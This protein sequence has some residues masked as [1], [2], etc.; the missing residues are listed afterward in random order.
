MEI[1]IKPQD[2][3]TLTNRH[4]EDENERQWMYELHYIDTY[5]TN[6]YVELPILVYDYWLNY[7]FFPQEIIPIV[8]ASGNTQSTYDMILQILYGDQ[9]GNTSGTTFVDQ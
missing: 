9:S 5:P 4:I 3:C 7:S 1:I 2:G 6:E 8:D